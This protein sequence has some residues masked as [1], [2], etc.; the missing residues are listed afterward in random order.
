[1]GLNRGSNAVYLS[2]FNGKIVQRVKTKTATSVTRS[3][4]NGVQVEEEIYKNIEGYIVGLD[5]K[6]HEEYGESLLIY[7]KDDK[8]YCLQLSMNSRFATNFFVL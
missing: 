8:L 6:V 5:T 3:N 2:I 4:K 1:M 7:I